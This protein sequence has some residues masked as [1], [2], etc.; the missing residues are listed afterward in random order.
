M[1]YGTPE[2]LAALAA[3][4]ACPA[5]QPSSAYRIGAA[6]RHARAEVCAPAG[7]QGRAWADR[8]ARAL[9]VEPS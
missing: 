7:S 4:G 3:L 9:Y 2:H 8:R 6:R 1:G 5:H